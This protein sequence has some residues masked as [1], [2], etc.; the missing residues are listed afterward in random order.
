MSIEKIKELVNKSE[1]EDKSE[2]VAFLD[3]NQE[4]PSLDKI[5]NDEKF[6]DLN[7]ELTSYIDGRI[8]KTR[9]KWEQEQEQQK[10]TEPQKKESNTEISELKKQNKEIMDALKVLTGK[11][12]QVDLTNYLEKKLQDK[13]K[14]KRLVKV[15]ENDTV[16]T[17]DE[18]IKEAEQTLSEILS[19]YDQSPTGAGKRKTTGNGNIGKEFAEKKLKQ[20]E[21][22]EE[23]TLDDYRN[24]N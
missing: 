4:K 14:V 3:A 8:G 24:K 6:A 9:T 7:K 23:I 21:V 1:L 20:Y 16:E 19:E 12:K 18:K 17:I 15:T 10:K 2:L 13:P 22:K 5:L 11:Q